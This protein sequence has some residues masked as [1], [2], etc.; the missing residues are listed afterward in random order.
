MLLA[1]TRYIWNKTATLVLLAQSHIFGG[2]CS[3]IQWFWTSWQKIFLLPTHH[4][5]STTP[6]YTRIDT[7]VLF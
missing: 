4:F 5:T 3:I 1:K 2:V 7:A 6:R